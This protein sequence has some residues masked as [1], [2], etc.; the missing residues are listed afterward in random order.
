MNMNNIIFIRM[1]IHAF[2]TYTHL[3]TS[4]SVTCTIVIVTINNLL[5][6]FE[7]ERER[8]MYNQQTAVAVT[9]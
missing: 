2:I 5:G 4:M 8:K 6:Q 3:Y 1:S 9:I 7:R